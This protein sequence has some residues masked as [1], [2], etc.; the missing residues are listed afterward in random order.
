MGVI[1]EHLG[2]GVGGL[3]GM[4]LLGGDFIDG[5]KH[6]WVDDACI[7]KECSIDGLDALDACGI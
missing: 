2:L 6:A 7:V 4:G 3:S 5:W 1:H